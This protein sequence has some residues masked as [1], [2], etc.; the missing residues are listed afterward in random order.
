M[1]FRKNAE[2]LMC[3]LKKVPSALACGVQESSMLIG[4]P[5]GEESNASSTDNTQKGVACS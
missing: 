2:H 4:D 1:D 5:L 3:D